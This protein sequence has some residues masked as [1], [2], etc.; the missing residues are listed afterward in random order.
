MVTPYRVLKLYD[1]DGTLHTKKNGVSNLDDMALVE[2][3]KKD[4]VLIV[5]TTG[6]GY[7]AALEKER[8]PQL[9]DV[10]VTDVGAVISYNFGGDLIGRPE[11]KQGQWAMDREW[12]EALNLKF[13][14]RQIKQDIQESKGSPLL[15]YFLESD[16]KLCFT[17]PKIDPSVDD[18]K[19]IGTNGQRNPGKMLSEIT[20]IRDNTLLTDIFYTHM[21]DKQ[22]YKTLMDEVSSV[23]R[24]PDAVIDTWLKQA[25]TDNRFQC[26]EDGLSN[27]VVPTLRQAGIK[28]DDVN[29]IV[30]KHLGLG[31]TYVDV[32][33]AGID[34]GTSGQ[35]L[36]TQLKKDGL[37]DDKT[38]IIAGGDS[39]NDF[40]MH[41][42]ADYF[43][44]VGNS[45]A[46]LVEQ[47][48]KQARPECKIIV[49]EGHAAAGL[50]EG[51]GKIREANPHLTQ[52]RGDVVPMVRQAAPT[53]ILKAVQAAPA[54][55]MG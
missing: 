23:S 41:T 39:R 29:V 54:R 31:D 50:M 21:K 51:Y 22:G 33:P 3:T 4:D 45:N 32:I 26:V 1:Y 43:V 42:V 38:V 17:L 46:G 18:I 25:K 12:S 40:E 55:K 28:M 9:A 8:I 47:L 11:E 7:D 49:V 36:I 13:D 10:L 14:K 30:S 15:K 48:Q 24:Q 2:A 53:P 27:A 19:R 6:N 5:V 20:G 35:H 37:I 52:E 44:A 16:F 34:K